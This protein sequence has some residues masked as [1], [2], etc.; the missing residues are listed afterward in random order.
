[1]FSNWHLLHGPFAQ[2]LSKCRTAT[3][4]LHPLTRRLEGNF[5][6]TRFLPV[7][8]LEAPPL[9]TG[10]NV[11]A[12]AAPWNARPFLQRF[13]GASNTRA[14]SCLL[15]QSIDTNRKGRKFRSFQCNLLAPNRALSINVRGG[16]AEP[17]GSHRPRPCPHFQISNFTF[18]R[19]KQHN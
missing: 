5:N 12:K 9:P 10:T 17:G 7:G 4:T 15:Y 13:D 19:F 1:M 16:V 6:C 18:N 3:N 8:R 2:L 14:W 11:I